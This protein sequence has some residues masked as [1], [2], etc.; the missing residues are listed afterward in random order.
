MS[1]PP[2]NQ[3]SGKECPNCHLSMEV[4]YLLGEYGYLFWS[5]PKIGPDGPHYSGW[6]KTEH[7]YP[8][9]TPTPPLSYRCVACRIYWLGQPGK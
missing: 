6:Q 3:P 4:G 8:G 1:G 7:V 2:V 9:I 5:P